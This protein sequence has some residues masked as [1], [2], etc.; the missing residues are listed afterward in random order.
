[1]ELRRSLHTTGNP[2][3]ALAAVRPAFAYSACCRS[4]T[5]QSGQAGPILSRR[6]GLTG[7]DWAPSDRRIRTYGEAASAITGR[8]ASEARH[9]LIPPSGEPPPATGP[10]G[11][12]LGR[13]PS[14]G[15]DELANRKSTLRCVTVSLRSASS[16]IPRR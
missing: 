9:S 15:A 5:G 7:A 4:R 3:S 10:L 2:V 11:I 16:R 1:V 13:S 8:Y 6:G 14:A 12:Y